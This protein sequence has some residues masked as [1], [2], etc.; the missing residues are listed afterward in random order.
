MYIKKLIRLLDK[1]ISAGVL[2]IIVVLLFCSNLC[3]FLK[4]YLLWCVCSHNFYV[5]DS[6]KKSPL[7][8]LPSKYVWYLSLCK[9][10]CHRRHCHFS[11]HSLFVQAAKSVLW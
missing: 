5:F 1:C 2:N 7:H 3:R 4:I 9:A 10:I 8:F 6:T 11:L